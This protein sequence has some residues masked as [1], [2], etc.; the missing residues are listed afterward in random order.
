MNLGL[1]SWSCILVLNPLKTDEAATQEQKGQSGRI[2]KNRKGRVEEYPRTERTEW[3]NAQEQTGQSGRMPDDRRK[4]VVKVYSFDEK[5][6]VEV[7]E[8]K[9]RGTRVYK[10]MDTNV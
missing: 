9:G 4:E 2:P 8:R 5:S 10:P 6:E 7:E 1:A 3:K